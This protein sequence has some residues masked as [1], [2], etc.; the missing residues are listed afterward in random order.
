MTQSAEPQ[1]NEDRVDI[2]YYFESKLRDMETR[3]DQR[4]AEKDLR[5]QQRYDAQKEAVATAM[6][7]QSTAMQTAL[8]AQQ[9]AVSAAQA[10]ADKATN[11]AEVAA[12]KRFDSTNEFR[13]Q[14]RDQA[15]TL[16]P[17][18][19]SEARLSNVVEKIE[20]LRVSQDIKTTEFAK[21]LDLIHGKSG[22][23]EQSWAIIV[24]VVV[25]AGIIVGIIVRFG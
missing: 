2:R 25:L 4:L 20:T 6:I 1:D 13:E 12:E 22:G 24:S 21:R 14:L 16:M 19:E 5:D 17:R 7:V 15:S 10:A 8:I 3:F 18:A 11:K 9:A 23:R